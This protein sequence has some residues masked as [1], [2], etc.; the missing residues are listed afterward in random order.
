MLIVCEFQRIFLDADD[1]FQSVISALCAEDDL[2]ARFDNGA[3]MQK[4]SEDVSQGA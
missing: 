3:A 4:L 2:H 1:S